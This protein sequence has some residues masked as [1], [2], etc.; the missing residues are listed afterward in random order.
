MS[1]VW[2]W[3]LSKQGQGLSPWDPLAVK[4]ERGI[5]YTGVY[6]AMTAPLVSDRNWI[7]K[8]QP[9]LGVQGAKPPGLTYLNSPPKPD[10][11]LTQW[12]GAGVVALHVDDDLAAVEVAAVIGGFGAAILAEDGAGDRD[13]TV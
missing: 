2:G 12:V 8:A 6:E 1:R 5:T 4:D 10:Q 11:F 7:A 13:A 9:V 3:F